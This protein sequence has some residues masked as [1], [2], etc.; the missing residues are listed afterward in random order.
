MLPL[1]LLL[2][3]GSRSTEG[4]NLPPHERCLKSF[5]VASP[6]KFHVSCLSHSNAAGTQLQQVGMSDVFKWD[7][8]GQN[9]K[10]RGA[11]GKADL[12]NGFCGVPLQA[13]RGMMLW[14]RGRWEML[15]HQSVVAVHRRQ[16]FA[17][18]A[19]CLPRRAWPVHPA[20]SSPRL[21]PPHKRPLQHPPEGG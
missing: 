17:T 5:R 12:A 14:S 2:V 8:D 1:V 15:P 16:K 19:E 11:T 4:Q 9:I 6:T 21:H 10:M 13:S 20:T 18:R 7:A 3:C